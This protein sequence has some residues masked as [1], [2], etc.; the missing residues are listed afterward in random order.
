MTN[1]EYMESLSDVE[2]GEKMATLGYLCSTC[3]TFND[4]LCENQGKCQTEW[5]LKEHT[6]NNEEDIMSIQ[7]QEKRR[8]YLSD[9]VEAFDRLADSFGDDEITLE[10]PQE[11][12]KIRLDSIT[13]DTDCGL[14]IN[15][16]NVQTYEE[17]K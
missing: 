8:Q 7:R 12:L 1:R 15:I 2:F 10:L 3:Y 4:S 9:F 13:L 5:L 16:N 11:T 14:L 17:F 6:E